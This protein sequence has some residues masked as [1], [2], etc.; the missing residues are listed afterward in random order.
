MLRQVLLFSKGCHADQAAVHRTAQPCRVYASPLAAAP[1]GAA[2]VFKFTAGAAGAVGA[3]A[4]AAC[5]CLQ[6]LD[7]EALSRGKAR[8]LGKQVCQ[9]CRIH[10]AAIV[11]AQ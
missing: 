11:A 4:S 10:L 5:C 7:V 2:A 9:L 6:A 1:T 8:H 3:V